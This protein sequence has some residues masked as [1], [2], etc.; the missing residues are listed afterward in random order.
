MEIFPNVMGIMSKPRFLPM[1]ENEETFNNNKAPVN[2]KVTTTTA[3]IN[4][5]SKVVCKVD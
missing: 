5:F 2:P 1:N 3:D 4:A